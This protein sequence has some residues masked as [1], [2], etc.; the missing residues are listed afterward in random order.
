LTAIARIRVASALSPAGIQMQRI[1]DAEAYRF[2]D[3]YRLFYDRG[4]LPAI[5]YIAEVLERHAESGAIIL[6]EPRRLGNAF[7]SLVVSGFVR[8]AIWGAILD[9]ETIEEGIAFNVR[10]FLDGVRTRDTPAAS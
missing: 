8:G 6:A 5:S 7:L 9:D 1:L 10:L 2:P 3:I 4:T